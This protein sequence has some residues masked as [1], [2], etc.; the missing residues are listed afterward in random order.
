MIN[1]DDYRLAWQVY[2]GVG[3]LAILVWFLLLRRI[4]SV[5]V[6]YWLFFAG[7]AFLFIPGRHPASPELW[8][9]G[10]AAAALT[11]LTEGIEDAMSIL[12]VMA[13][14]QILALILA[15][16]AMTWFTSEQKPT[17][18]RP[19]VKKSAKLVPN[20]ERKEPSL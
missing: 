17:K 9:P 16:A 1:L 15:L 6:R 11:L 10:S 2:M 13:A 7:L 4:S 20:N 3:A 19:A 8:V 5:F 12:I 14:G 18:S